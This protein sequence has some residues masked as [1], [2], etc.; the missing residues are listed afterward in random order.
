MLLQQQKILKKFNNEEGSILILSLLVSF[1]LITLCGGVLSM[2]V[3]E[4]RNVTRLTSS[5]SAMNL[6]EAG[7]DYAIWEMNYNNGDFSEDDGWADPNADDG[8][9]SLVKTVTFQTAAGDD[10]GEYVM[11]VTDPGTATVTISTIAFVPSQSSAIGQRTVK[12]GLDRDNTFSMAVFGVDKV[13]VGNNGIMD[14]FNSTEGAYGGSNINSN[15][16]IATDS[17]DSGAITIG[18]T[19]SVSGDATIG[20]GGDTEVAIVAPD[21]TL[22]GDQLVAP[23][24]EAPEAELAPTGLT[25]RADISGSATISASG[26]YDNISAGR[27]DIITIDSD[28]TL[29]VTNALSLGRD[30]RIDIINGATVRIYLGSTLLSLDQGSRINNVSENP[31]KFGLYGTPEFVD[32][33]ADSAGVQIDQGSVFY[34]TIH[35]PTASVEIGLNATVYGA[36][37]GNKVDIGNGGA[38][39]FDEALLESGGVGSPTYTVSY[40]QE[41]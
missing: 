6:A 36:I 32:P 17:I 27:N 7:T 5:M 11:T 41:K 10:V 21:G 4:S 29:Y 19:A 1:I 9:N 34:G 23:S 26:V 12:V 37:I 20:P 31:L 38:V 15:G 33:G 13:S 3:T 14:S 30:S 28:V 8:I 40:W 18:G 2:T 16:D 35:T 39:H 25:A 24:S 22:S